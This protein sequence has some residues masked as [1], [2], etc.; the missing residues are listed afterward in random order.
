MHGPALARSCRM[1]VPVWHAHPPHACAGLARTPS[2]CMCRP[3]TH[4]LRVHV[5]ARHAHPPHACAGPA[6]TP[7]ACMCRPG[8]RSDIKTQNVFVSKDG[9]L[10]LGDFGVSKVRKVWVREVRVQDSML[11]VCRHP[12]VCRALLTAH[13]TKP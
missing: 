1:H 5:P 3:G 12:R 4:T 8:V 7:S 9:I 2:A 11:G 6:R 10:K 13:C